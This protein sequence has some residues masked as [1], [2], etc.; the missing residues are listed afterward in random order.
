MSLL[1]CN[2]ASDFKSN[3]MLNRI[4]RMF[5]LLRRCRH[6][7]G[8]GIQ[9]P[10]AYRFVR[11]VV[12]EHYPYY[13]YDELKKTSPLAD[14]TRL[15]LY[16]LYFRIANFAQAEQWTVCLSGQEVVTRYI[17]AGC[18]KTRVINNLYDNVADSLK[19]STILLVDLRNDRKE[20]YLQFIEHAGQHSI[21][22]INGIYTTAESIR[23]WRRIEQDY[24]TGITFDLYYCGI[25]F[26]DMKKHKQNYIINF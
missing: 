22:I 12:N 24:R 13:A 8:F 11:Y 19:N 20:T 4:K 17:N 10:W 23:I 9:S 21:L 7:R 18:K 2:F 15:K 6:C 1:C 25:V 16:R 26:F 3:Q 14:K 5:I